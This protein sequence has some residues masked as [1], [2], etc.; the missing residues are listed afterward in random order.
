MTTTDATSLASP[1]GALYFGTVSLTTLGCNDIT[2]VSQPAR[3]QVSLEAT[4]GVLCMA[5]LVCAVGCPLLT[6]SRE[7]GMIR[8]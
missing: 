2:P 3:G 4:V 8:A 5:V 6:A 1:F 7:G